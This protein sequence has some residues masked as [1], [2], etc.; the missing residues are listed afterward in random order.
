LTFYLLSKSLD[1][2]HTEAMRLEPAPDFDQFVDGL[3]VS[4][5]LKKWMKKRHSADVAGTDFVKSLTADNIVDVPEFY[6]AYMSRN[7]GF[8]GV[9]FPK[10]KYKEK[11]REANPEKYKKEK[12]EYTAAIRKF[13]AAVP[14][15]V[16][17]IDADLTDIDASAKWRHL[18][19][20]YKGRLKDRT[21]E[22][23]EQKYLAGQTDTDLDGNGSFAGLAPGSYWISMI[24]IQAISGDVRLRWDLPVSVRPGETTRVEL[25]NLNAAKSSDTAENSDH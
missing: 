25:T 3:S 16:Q 17:G 24:G 1:D 14:E 13:I 15:S 22:L 2:I 18:Q 11:D 10:L 21:I 19:S 7:A 5:E 23:A 9:G 6:A 20:L 12:E 4:P 8:K